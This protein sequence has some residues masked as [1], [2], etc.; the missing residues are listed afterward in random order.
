MIPEQPGL[1]DARPLVTAE[2]RRTDWLERVLRTNGG[3]MTAK[4]IAALMTHD[5]FQDR[6]IRQIA[7]ESSNVISGQKGYKHIAHSSAE[8]IDHAANWLES[9]AKKMSERACAIRRNA[10]R[11]FA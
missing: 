11:V 6:E 1:F 8:E 4:E 5:N 7:S 3:W 2:A 10:H 9:Q